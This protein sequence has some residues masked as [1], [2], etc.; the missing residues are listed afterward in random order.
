MAEDTEILGRERDSPGCPEPRPILKLKQEPPLVIEHSDNAAPIHRCGSCGVLPGVGHHY[1]GTNRLNVVRREI[2]GSRSVL[3]LPGETGT[4][5]ILIEDLDLILAEVRRQQKVSAVATFVMAVDF[6]ATT[7]VAGGPQPAMVPFRVAKM[8]A[9]GLL[10]ARAKS[11]VPLNIMP[12]GTE[13]PATPCAF[14]IVTTRGT[15]APA[16]VYKVEVPVP[17]LLTHQ[18]LDA[19]RATP[20]ALTKL[21]STLT[22]VPFAF[23]G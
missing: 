11:A 3:E 4:D 9:A 6:P 22:A 21:G 8:N 2:R 1:Q 17:P 16:P 14:G 18:G 13:G 23:A 19:P 10:A 20:H 5:E 12:V 7:G 15:V